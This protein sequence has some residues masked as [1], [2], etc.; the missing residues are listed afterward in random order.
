MDSKQTIGK[1][2]EK[3]AVSYLQRHDYTVIKTNYHTRYGEIDIV[4]SKGDELIFVE[5]KTR[6]T[7]SGGQPEAAVGRIKLGRL[8]LAID[9]YCLTARSSQPFRLDVISIYID[10]CGTA[11]L[12]H[13]IN[14]Q[15]PLDKN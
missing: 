4:C 15:N 12:T 9:H 1:C 14:C 3:I 13:F 6:T 2:G 7:V 11:H 5:V 8:A 10:R